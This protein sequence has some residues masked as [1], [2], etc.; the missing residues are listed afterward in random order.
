M[1]LDTLPAEPAPDVNIKRDH[2]PNLKI[3]KFGDGYSQR[4]SFG[5]NQVSLDIT[6]NYS[7]ISENEK[8]ELEE[9]INDH[10]RGQAFE[11]TLPDEPEPRQFHITGWSITYVKFRV[12]NVSI[13]LEENFDIA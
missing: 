12:F 4:T 9:F 11:Y 2:K 7:N 3:A 1:P 10:N 13:Q 6:L 8:I 5:P